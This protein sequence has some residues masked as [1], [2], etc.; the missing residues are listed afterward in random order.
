MSEQMKNGQQAVAA[1]NAAA[2]AA[3]GVEAGVAADSASAED[4]RLELDTAQI[5]QILPHRYPFALVDRITDG[6]RGSWA[7]GRLC[8]SGMSPVFCGHFP[9]YPVMP[10][11]LIIEA[12]AQVAAVAALSMPE[13]KGRLGFFAAIKDAKFRRQVR[14]GD[15]LELESHITRMRG[16]FAFVDAEAR[17]DGQVAATAQLTLA[18][19]SSEG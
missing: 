17:V 13:N 7:H 12:L 19:G 15:V 14:P 1:E 4:D 18:L 5:A 16:S 10:G 2:V 8:V 11:V 6:K 3:A 9:Q